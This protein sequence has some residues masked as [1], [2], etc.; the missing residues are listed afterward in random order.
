M[1]FRLFN[2]G[3]AVLRGE[4]SWKELEVGAIVTEPGSAAEYRTGDWR[5]ERPVRKQELCIMCGNCYIY[6]PEG[7]VV[8]KDG[9]Y[10]T[11]LYY[12]KG[13]GICAHECPRGAIEMVEEG[14]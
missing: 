6:C 7:C 9:R 14:E 13:C 8:F 4:L 11:E 1:V 2:L 3:G 5:S 10:E 12:C